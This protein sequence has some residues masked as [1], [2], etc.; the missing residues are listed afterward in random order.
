MHSVDEMQDT[1]KKRL[2]SG[3][4]GFAGFWTDHSLPSQ[5]S[6]RISDSPPTAVQAVEDVHDTPQNTLLEVGVDWIDHSLP[7]Q[8]STRGDHPPE[9]VSCSP[10]AVQASDE[11]H[12][13]ACR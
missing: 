8:L 11:L 5:L 3:L 12:D 1:S 13:T 4:V 10:T 6:I 7:F 2:S 9:L